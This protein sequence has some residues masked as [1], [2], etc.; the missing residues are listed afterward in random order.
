MSEKSCEDLIKFDYKTQDTLPSTLL[1]LVNAGE[2]IKCLKNGGELVLSQ[3]QLGY[4][5]DVLRADLVG[6]EDYTDKSKIP[7]LYVSE[8]PIGK[9]IYFDPTNGKRLGDELGINAWFLEN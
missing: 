9:N 3:K 6:K 4:E 1:S 7:T 5:N 2:I 8:W